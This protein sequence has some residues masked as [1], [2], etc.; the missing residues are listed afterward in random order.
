MTT[1]CGTIPQSFK[2]ICEKIKIKLQ[3]ITKTR[4]GKNLYLHP[5]G[6][7]PSLRVCEAVIVPK[8]WLWFVESAPH[9]PFF[10]LKFTVH[11]RKFSTAQANSATSVT[12]IMPINID[13]LAVT[14][15]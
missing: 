3:K 13:L 6:C 7:K 2:E 15:K 14:Q 5:E 8:M 12:V 1:R 10:T 9:K 4:K 11:H